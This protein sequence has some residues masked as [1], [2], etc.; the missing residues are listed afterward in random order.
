[1]GPS[2]LMWPA[3]STTRTSA[4]SSLTERRRRSKVH[5]SQVNLPL[6]LSTSL[7]NIPP[8]SNSVASTPALSP[9]LPL[10]PLTP[11]TQKDLSPSWRIRVSGGGGRGVVG[12]RVSTGEPTWDYL[13]CI[14]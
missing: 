7:N 11:L 4:T 10:S 13:F 14:K 5:L 12:V 8:S 2:P 6:S 1:M 9:P 3:T